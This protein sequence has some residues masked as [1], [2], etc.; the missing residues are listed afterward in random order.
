M[1]TFVFNDGGRSKYFAA[2]G[3]G[4]CVVR[5]FAIAANKDYKEVYNMAKSLCKKGESPRNGLTKT[6]C[7]KLGTMLGG[8]WVACSGIGTGC[9][10]HL[11]ADEL[12]K[13]RIV[14]NCS[15][16]LVAAIDGVVNDTYDSTRGGT[17]C[18]YGYWKF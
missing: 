18:V 2:S 17:R 10:M 3:V 8:V 7:H 5:A 14:C 15:K 1:E 12:P 9:K 4:D 13:G 16:H 6:N 11:K